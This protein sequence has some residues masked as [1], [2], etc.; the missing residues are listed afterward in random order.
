MKNSRLLLDIMLLIFPLLALMLYIFNQDATW[1]QSISIILIISTIPSLLLL[2]YEVVKSLLNHKFGVDLLAILSMSGALWMNEPA[3]AAV[4]AAMTAS[5]RFLENYARGRAE[6][7]MVALLSR[8]PRVA[9]RLTEDGIQ[10]IPVESIQPG[11]LLLVKLGE[12][13]P[14]DGPLVSV[15]AV[16]NESSI[17]GESLPV[18]RQTG[19][20]LLSGTINAGDALKMHAA[21][22]AKDSTLQGIISVVEQAGQ[23]RAPAARLAD[24]YAVWFIPFTLIVAWLAWLVSQDPIRALA[25]LVVATPCPLLLAVPVALVSGISRCAK[26][27]ILIKG[28]AALEQLAR[29]DYLFFDKTGTLTGGMAKLMSI[30]SF[31]PHFSQPDL[32]KLAASMDQLSCHVIASAIL[33]AAQ[34]QG[35]GSLPMP[36][37]V[38]E[39]AGAGL[40]GKV[41]G[42]QVCLGTL[43]FVLSQ[44]RAGSWLESAR[45]RLF[46]ENSTVV[47]IAV[48]AELVGWLLFSDQLR[49]E[50]P[51][52]LRMLRKSG[53]HEIVMLTGDKQEV[54]D[55]IGTGLGVDQVLAELTPEMKLKYVSSASSAH[56]TM[57]VG[58]GV[59][60]APALAAAGVGVA[61][62]A[63]GTAAAAESADVVLLTDRLDRLA[64]AKAIAKLSIRIARQS[65]LLGMGLCCVAMGFAA[66]GLLP[67]FEGA[68]LQELIDLLAIMSALRVLASGIARPAD[69]TMSA[70]QVATLRNEHQMLQPLLQRLTEVATQ[71]PLASPEER[72]TLMKTLHEQLTQDILAHEQQDEQGLYPT[73]TL[74]LAGDDPL[75]AMSRSHQ[76]IYLLVR[77]LGQL[78]N[79]L[80]NTDGSS[81]TV[82]DIQQC[83]YGLEAILRLH[84]AQE[85]ELFSGLQK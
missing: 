79:L 8:V 12:T 62:G 14:V 39:V 7:E 76:E 21:R 28:S 38:Q 29:A 36:E 22:A 47:A 9:N 82:Q 44:A 1:V 3:T 48:N 35:L 20:L 13:I 10:V 42:Q 60:D 32:L 73:M 80:Q 5:G 50:T 56:C 64:E 74:M 66:L 11:Y 26:R 78:S 51:R 72:R 55:S 68:L 57:M 59:N 49:L 70:E 65:V 4:I 23:A 85:E 37:S 6:R 71:L 52:A 58:D 67:P 15:S 81:G 25:V 69:K 16:L 40:T 53:V 43:D 33:Q 75:A 30:H 18:T 27:G 46:I 24:R 77:K 31:S 83:L 63:R 34:E 45:Q 2:I 17:T 19:E 41:N 84:F 54:A 61:M